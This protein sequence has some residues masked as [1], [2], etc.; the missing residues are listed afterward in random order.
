MVYLQDVERHVTGRYTGEHPRI[1][2][3]PT[4]FLSFII[5][6]ILLL[7]LSRE[8]EALFM[9]KHGVYIQGTGVKHIERQHA[10]YLCSMWHP[11]APC[12]LALVSD[13]GP[14]YKP[15]HDPKIRYIGASAR[16]TSQLSCRRE[17]GRGVLGGQD[18]AAD[19]SWAVHEITLRIRPVWRLGRR[20]RN[21]PRILAKF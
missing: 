15:L 3:R 6:I 1:S 7:L 5:I 16:A 19:F 21:R 14:S 10:Y 9:P 8:S 2:A 17:V 13:A 4:D 11:G 18:G 12:R 20:R